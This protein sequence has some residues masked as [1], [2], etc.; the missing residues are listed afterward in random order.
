MKYAIKGSQGYDIFG[1]FYNLC[2]TTED[3]IHYTCGTISHMHSKKYINNIIIYCT[4]I[5]QSQPISISITID[6][7]CDIYENKSAKI[8]R[9]YITGLMMSTANY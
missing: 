7:D 9:T 6:I 4:Y 5:S 1:N 3:Q 2:S 8:C